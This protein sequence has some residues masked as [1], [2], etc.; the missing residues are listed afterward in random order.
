MAYEPEIHRRRSIRLQGYDY[1]QTGAYFATLCCDHRKCLFGEILG[2][3]MR[4]NNFGRVVQTVWNELPDHYPDVALD[5]FV[6]MPNHVHGI[7]MLTNG[8]FT[9]S[10]GAGL[11]PAPTE[12]ISGLYPVGA[13]F[14][15]APR[16]HSLPEIIRAL[17]TFSAKN[18]N[19]LRSTSG[20]P[21]WQRNY[22]ERVIRNEEELNA[23][24]QY[25]A[26]NPARWNEDRNHPEN[27]IAQTLGAHDTP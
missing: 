18:I 1:S 22:Y 23:A 20:V 10:L 6:I 7:I 2:E 13:G 3:E 19:L 4:I 17:K 12:D 9:S 25:I 24:R 27:I 26:D 15:P 14:K 8:N 16:R 21:V 11:K 5:A